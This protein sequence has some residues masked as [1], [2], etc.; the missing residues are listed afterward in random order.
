M[1]TLV[2]YATS[3]DRMDSWDLSTLDVAPH[4]PQVLASAEET[5]IV[6]INLPAGEEMQEHQT[7]ERTYLVV[8]DGEV[9]VVQDGQST[10]GGR[11]FLAHFEPAE[12]RQV[13]AASDSRLLLVLAPWPGVGHPSRRD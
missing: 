6:A 11:G 7:H 12:R 9:D 2:A 5:R 10:R 13:R 8:V 3:A 4:H 1:T